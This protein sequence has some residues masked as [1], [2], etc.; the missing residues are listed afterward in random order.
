MCLQCLCRVRRH[1][2]V[3]YS[4]YWVNCCRPSRAADS[5]PL[6]SKQSA[7]GGRCSPFVCLSSVSGPAG[8]L[9]RVP[10]PGDR[11]QRAAAGEDIGCG[12]ER[13]RRC[14][15]LPAARDHAGDPGVAAAGGAQIPCA[16]T[17]TQ[18]VLLCVPAFDR[19]KASADLRSG[20]G[21]LL[22]LHMQRQACAVHA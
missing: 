10:A 6:L 4:R 12:L 15:L 7:S 13:R 3:L 14:V 18:C 16:S 21:Q 19:A 22:H 1:V 8:V 5:Q 17:C 2:Q 11:D 20:V 9:G